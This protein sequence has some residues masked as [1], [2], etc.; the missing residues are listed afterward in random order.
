MRNVYRLIFGMLSLVIVACDTEPLNTDEILAI[1]AEQSSIPA[2]GVSRIQITAHVLQKRV[3][4]ENR[5]VTFATTAGTLVGADTSGE[6]KVPLNDEF[7]AS[8]FLKSN[9]QP[10]DIAVVTG[11]VGK[12]IRATDFYESCC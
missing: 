4:V 12:A 8:V 5:F 11:K 2:D 3:N 1:Y 7:K 6:I 10:S 9:V